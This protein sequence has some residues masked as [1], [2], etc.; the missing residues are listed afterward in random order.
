[1]CMLTSRDSASGKKLVEA[2]VI[3]QEYMCKWPQRS[4]TGR[5][6]RKHTSESRPDQKLESL[7]SPTDFRITGSRTDRDGFSAARAWNCFPI[8]W[9][10][11]RKCL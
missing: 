7:V 1:M 8:P 3:T 2:N 9:N 6:N 4:W 5:A 10:H 11:S